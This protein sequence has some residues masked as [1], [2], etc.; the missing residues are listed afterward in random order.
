MQKKDPTQILAEQHI[1]HTYHRLPI[2]LVEGKGAYV[3][4]STG[5]EY[6]DFLSGI[7]CTPLGHQHT[8]V[9]QAILNQAQKILHTSNVYYNVPS[10]KLAA[11]LTKNGGLDKVFFCNSGAE[12][13]E[14]AFKLARKYQWRN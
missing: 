1:L 8:N 7:A 6:L 11:Y 2:T 4:D 13:N 9:V 10:A 5:K 14:T 3:K 12:A